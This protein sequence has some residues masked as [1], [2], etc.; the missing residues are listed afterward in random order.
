MFEIDFW[1]SQISTKAESCKLSKVNDEINSKSYGIAFQPGS[2]Y[3][4]IFSLG[5]L[6]M[7]D[8]G[9]LEKIEKRWW[10]NEAVTC[11]DKSE[12]SQKSEIGMDD[13]AGVFVVFVVGLAVAILTSAVEITCFLWKN[14]NTSQDDNYDKLSV[15]EQ[16][17]QISQISDKEVKD[18]DWYLVKG[19][20]LK[21]N[22]KWDSK[23]D[24]TSL[25][26]EIFSGESKYI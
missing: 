17:E 3:A 8:S 7:Q 16:F 22:T 15:S 20:N 18:D 9:S 4:Q 10:N 1:Y 5:I 2:K 19:K 13:F 11:E 21:I 14:K 24:I 6:L 26:T 23:D 12:R 25:E